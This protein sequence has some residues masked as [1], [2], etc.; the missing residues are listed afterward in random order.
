MLMLFC[1]LHLTYT[2]VFVFL[3]NDNKIN[4]I[5]SV[6]VH[7]AI[8]RPKIL[9]DQFREGLNTL[10]FSDQLKKHPDIFR[11]LFVRD[12]ASITYDEL[13]QCLCFPSLMDEDETSTHNFLKEF[14]QKASNETLSNF[15]TFATGAPCLPNFGLGTI[16]VKFESTESIFAST[17]LQHVT[18]PKQFPDQ[19]TFR[20]VMDSVLNT[21][22]K[23][24][25]NV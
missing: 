9:L 8:S 20:T 17:C 25:T 2:A 7:D 5:H 3:Q 14:L 6:M 13:V 4:V 12:D 24:F 21:V 1:I 16:E 22:A 15:L 11:Q 19:A 23:S 10:G 18:F